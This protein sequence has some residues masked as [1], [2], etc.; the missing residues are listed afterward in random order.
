MQ[1]N[2]TKINDYTLRQTWEEP[3]QK[4]PGYSVGLK[5]FSRITRTFNFLSAQVTTQTR[6]ITF[7]TRGP[8]A[9]GSSSVAA[10]TVVQ[11]F[12][13]FQS[14]LEIRAMHKKLVELEGRPPELEDVLSARQNL[15]GKPRLDSPR[16]TSSAPGR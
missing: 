16:N 1:E 4:M 2:F 10:Q 11:N 7:E 15:N 6:D 13:E 14:D 5:I 9:G 3:E 8:D 12:N